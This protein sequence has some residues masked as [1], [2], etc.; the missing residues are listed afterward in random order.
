MSQAAE[1]KLNADRD[2]AILAEAER[3]RRSAALREFFEEYHAEHGPFTDEEMAEASRKLGLPWPPE[4]GDN[5]RTG[6]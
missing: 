6:A 1:A 4:E 3:K 2:S 5:E